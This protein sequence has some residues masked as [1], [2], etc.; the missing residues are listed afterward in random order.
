MPAQPEQLL[1][2]AVCRFARLHKIP[3]LHVAN[4]RKASPYFGSLLK[5]MGVRPGV[6]DCLFPRGNAEFKGLWLEL[7]V[8]KRKPTPLQTQFLNEMKAEGYQA[9]WCQGID[10]A[11]EIIKDFYSIS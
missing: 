9:L 3:F 2:I 11:M 1:Q 4:E 10:A 6:A 8:A 7:K 5:D